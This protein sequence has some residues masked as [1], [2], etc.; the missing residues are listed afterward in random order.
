MLTPLLFSRSTRLWRPCV[1]SHTFPPAW[2]TTYFLVCLKNLSW[3]WISYTTSLHSGPPSI[4]TLVT[5]RNV[6]HLCVYLTR[7]WA[8]KNKDSVP[9]MELG[10][11]EAPIYLL[12]RVQQGNQTKAM[13]EGSAIW[14]VPREKALAWSQTWLMSHLSAPSMDCRGIQTSHFFLQ[15]II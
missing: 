5:P 7:R 10:S 15:L 9:G 6:V 3:C 8:P 13:W 1:F 2:D 14:E 11:E 12:N 4:I